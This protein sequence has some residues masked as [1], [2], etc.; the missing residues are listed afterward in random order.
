MT[1]RVGLTYDVK[2]EFVL[3]PGDPPDLNAEFDHD[4][5]I[6]VIETAL[7]SAG[8]HVVRIGNARQLLQQIGTPDVD[9]VFNIAE[10]YVG[11]NR[12][13]Q[14]PILLEMM[15][16]PF[17]GAD[18]LTLG[19]TLDKVLTKKVLIAEGIPT[20]RY[21][22]V[23]DPEKL[24][25]LDLTYPLIAK[26]RCEGSSKGLSEK[27]LV[28]SPADLRRQVTWLMETYKDSS[29][30]IEEFIEG[31][32]FTVAIIGND[33]PDI[34]PVVQISLD[35]QTKLGRKFFTF[36]YLRSGADYICPAPIPEPLAKRMQE[37]ALRT[38]Q[39]VE[40]RDFGRVDFRVDRHGRPYVLEI[41][42]LPSLSNEDVFN[43]VAKT[44][45]MTHLQIIN[46]ILE[47]AL[48]RY[49]MIPPPADRGV[50]LGFQR[51]TPR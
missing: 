17:V 11:R 10:G 16:M 14:V 37:L 20:P 41:N 2:S 21:V 51:S 43:F 7:K 42:P 40:C 1:F 9:I 47:A 50:V 48:V 8:H 22:E 46:Q 32:E 6:G 34:Y 13:S 30:F 5:T 28:D 3:K 12:E 23:S 44:K 29:V 27:S 19:L 24:W 4:E 35:G 45:G 25:Q 31:E 36:A 49:G 18:G 33:A 15:R 39:A 38:Y 26:L